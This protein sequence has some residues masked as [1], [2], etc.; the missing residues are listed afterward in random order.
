MA[1]VRNLDL[2]VCDGKKRRHGFGCMS[3][4][5]PGGKELPLP[6]LW[7][8]HTF[9]TSVSL[10]ATLE[11]IKAFLIKHPTEV[12]L[13]QVN[14]DSAKCRSLTSPTRVADCFLDSGLPLAP[15]K[16]ATASSRQTVAQLAG[17]AIVMLQS[18]LVDPTHPQR[19]MF[20]PLKSL[21][22]QTQVWRS[23]TKKNAK[24]RLENHMCSERGPEQ[25]PYGITIDVNLAPFQTV[26]MT[27]K[28]LN[29]WF[30][31]RLAQGRHDREKKQR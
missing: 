2:R 15:Y 5:I 29:Q 12:V 21:M 30:V 16:D 11:D 27:A 17:K 20:W 9:R 7:L 3:T 31:S 26:R 4:S 25:R 10:S 6:E 13:I 8:S 19:Q 23:C 28:K 14:A 24:K 18:N 22:R 1:G